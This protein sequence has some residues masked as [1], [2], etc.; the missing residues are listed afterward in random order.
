MEP[1]LL[2]SHM[3]TLNVSHS[4]HIVFFRSL[5]T[6][7]SWGATLGL[8][9][10]RSATMTAAGS[11]RSS[12]PSSTLHR[13]KATNHTAPFDRS[14]DLI[15]SRHH[16]SSRGDLLPICA[17]G[18]A[19]WLTSTTSTRPLLFVRRRRS[20]VMALPVCCVHGPSP[21]NWSAPGGEGTGSNM[22]A[23]GGSSW[24]YHIR[25]YLS[26]ALSGGSKGPPKQCWSVPLERS[27]WRPFLSCGLV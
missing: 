13:G 23:P 7:V 15:E 3:H 26:T 1:A 21:G 10:V 20:I 9:P 11:I 27:T 17:E 2:Y 12:I 14:R 19:V 8:R 18:W 25:T 16:L 6:P 5:A 4:R 24:P 22:A